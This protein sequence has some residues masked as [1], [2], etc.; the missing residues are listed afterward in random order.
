MVIVVL[1]IF[2]LTFLIYN[3]VSVYWLINSR[4]IIFFDR[5]KTLFK[6]LFDITYSQNYILRSVMFFLI[7][8]NVIGNVPLSSARTLFYFNTMTMS[9]VLWLSLLVVIVE[10]QFTQYLSHIIPYG[11]PVLLVVILPLV[12][13]FSQFIRPL[14]LIIR[15]RTNLSAGHIILYMFS[16]FSLFSTVLGGFIVVLLIALFVL[17]VCIS[18][19]QAYI[20]V[21]LSCIYLRES[22]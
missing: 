10:T 9:L 21:S 22:L 7:F 12:E 6:R 11:A 13:L 3:L 8:R 17:E 15:L 14:T 18:M 1:F 5:I 19:L 4:I 2:L 16:F 20:F